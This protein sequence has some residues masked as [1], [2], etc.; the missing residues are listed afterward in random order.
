MPNLF[1]AWNLATQMAVCNRLRLMHKF[2]FYLSYFP[3]LAPP[4]GTFLVLLG[5][6]CDGLPV[7]WEKIHVSLVSGLSDSQPNISPEA[8][9]LVLL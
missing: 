7:E 9:E 8:E 3:S 2:R 5:P 1:Y 6:K 4:L